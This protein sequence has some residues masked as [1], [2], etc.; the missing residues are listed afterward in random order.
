MPGFSPTGPERQDIKEGRSPSHNL[1]STAGRNLGTNGVELSRVRAEDISSCGAAQTRLAAS[2]RAGCGWD[3]ATRGLPAGATGGLPARRAPVAAGL[4]L[5]S[6]VMKWDGRQQRREPARL[7]Q[8]CGACRAPSTDTR[9]LPRFLTPWGRLLLAKKVVCLFVCLFDYFFIRVQTD[10][11]KR[12]PKSGVVCLGVA[13]LSS[14][15]PTR[16]LAPFPD[17]TGRVRGLI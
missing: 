8:G 2:K 11:W 9:L 17:P 10:L 13:Q 16:L 7:R 6:V 14:W 12:S 4:E 15:A 3:G 1:Y 5:L